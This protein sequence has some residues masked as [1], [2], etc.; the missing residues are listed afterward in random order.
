MDACDKASI[1][2]EHV[3]MAYIIQQDQPINLFDAVMASREAAMTKPDFAT[4]LATIDEAKVFIKALVAAGMLFHFEDSPET[5]ISGTTGK[6]LFTR[7][8]AKLVRQRVAELYAMDW[9]TVG[10]ECPIGYALEIDGGEP[11]TLD[12]LTEEFTAFLTVHK[13]PEMAAEEL[14]FETL[15]D[16]ERKWVSMFIRR[17]EAVA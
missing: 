3:K 15:T 17:W 2:S 4:S 13:L 10:H 9:P 11:V 14:I 16:Y 7:A 8:E 6:A 5:I 12:R 1:R